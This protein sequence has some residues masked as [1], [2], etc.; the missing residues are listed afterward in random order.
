MKAPARFPSSIPLVVRN[1]SVRG[2]K[3]SLQVDMVLDTGADITLLSWSV[4]RFLGYDPVV[5]RLRRKISTANGII[6]VPL[7]R[8][9]SIAVRG[10]TAS[11]VEVI[12]HDLPELAETQGLL[13]LSYLKHFRTI[14]DYKKGYVEIY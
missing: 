10:A 11:N 9:E 2:P 13:G 3:R 12:A 4:L 5:S 8:I 6:V 1:V 7:L 14:I